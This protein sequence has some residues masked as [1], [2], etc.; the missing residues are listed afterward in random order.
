MFFHFSIATLSSSPFSP[1][2][3]CT[4][5]RMAPQGALMPF[6]IIC[7]THISLLSRANSSQ[8]IPKE[9]QGHELISQ[10]SGAGKRCRHHPLVLEP[11]WAKK[12][13]HMYVSVWCKTTGG[14]RNANGLAW[15]AEE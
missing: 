11:D 9:Q 15:S 1:S 12:E 8:N 10:P 4:G 14:V 13:P 3:D 7:N 5:D 2:A 6:V